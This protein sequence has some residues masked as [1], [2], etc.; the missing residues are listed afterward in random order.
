MSIAQD[1]HHPVEQPAKKWILSTRS[2]GNSA[3]GLIVF[4]GGFVFFEP[5]PYELLLVPLLIIWF[6]FGLTL[7]RAF[8]PL[9]FL[10]LCFICGGA[11]A[12]TQKADI[13]AGFF[14]IIVTGFLVT[15]SIFFAA[16]VANS[17]QERL[18][19]IFKAYCFTAIIGSLI[20]IL[21]YFH[22]LPNSESYL[23][24]GRARGPFQDPNVFG[25]FLVLPA[26]FLLRNIL[27]NST[28]KSLGSIL[29]LLIIMSAI[30]LAFSRAAWG[31]TLVACVMMTMILFI[32]APDQRL[33]SKIILASIFMGALMVVFFLIALSVDAISSLFEERARLVQS[34]DSARFGRFA[35]YGFALQWIMEGPLGYGFGKSR[36][37]FGED[38]H[39]VYIKAFLVYGWLGGI[40]YL[41]LVLSTLLVGFKHLF[42]ITPW[43]GYFQCCYVVIFGHAIVG[44]VVDIDRW[45]HLYLIYGI[46]WGMIAA[47]TIL[48]S[49][50]M[51]H[52]KTH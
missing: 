33:R 31:L 14:Y 35:R 39:N 50:K 46:A 40:S 1:I 44:L 34:Y 9:T 4:L 30:F 7:H 12:V 15:T 51:E 48:Q 23:F 10:M 19:I 42:K 3:L 36:E 26:V 27:V 18:R 8:L 41:A 16:V 45:R 37:A 32:T 52:Q 17:P 21:A 11:I 38:T 47:Y 43:Q 25:P 13:A 29:G 49:R 22:L 2:L 20:G 6:A 28:G 5:A 24:G